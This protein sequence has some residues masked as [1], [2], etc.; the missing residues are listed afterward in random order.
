ME[1]LL[2]AGLFLK[3]LESERFI[4]LQAAINIIVIRYTYT[5]MLYL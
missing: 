1:I 5:S 3:S 2:R 4:A